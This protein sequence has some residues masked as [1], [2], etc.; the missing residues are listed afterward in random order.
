MSNPNS[1]QTERPWV[2]R[3]ST[4]GHFFTATRMVHGRAFRVV[5]LATCLALMASKSPQANG[6]GI[7]ELEVKA[8]IR[9]LGDPSFAARVRA[10]EGL[11]RMGLQAFD[12]LHE[13]QFNPDSEIAMTARFLVSSL[14]VQWHTD[15][16][17][18]VVRE[19]L[20]EYGAQSESE[21]QNR[22]DR[23][24]ELPARQGLAA[25]CRLARYET[26][27]RLSRHAALAIMRGTISDD[28]EVR[29]SEAETILSVLGSNDRQASN[30]LR[31]Y[32]NDL[33]KGDYD[34]EAWNR[35]VREQ[36]AAADG[37]DPNL[38]QPVL[39]ELVRV[40]ANRALS[41]DRPEEALRLA[42]E[43]L[44]LVPPEY[45]DLIDACGWAIDSGLHPLVLRL[46][47]LHPQ[48]FEGRPLLLY[49]AAEAVLDVEKDAE[50]AEELAEK[51]AAIDPLKP[52]AEGDAPITRESEELGYRHRLIARQLQARGLFR[53]AEREYRHIID[54]LPLTSRASAGARVDFAKMLGELLRHREVVEILLP[55]I[56]RADVDQQFARDAQRQA[57]DLNMMRSLVYFHR[58][59]DEVQSKTPEKL[60]AA[61]QSFINALELEPRNIDILI[62]MYR[63]DGDE[64]WKR[65]IRRQIQAFAVMFDNLIEM[66]ESQAQARARFMNSKE[67]LAD[68][69]NQYAWLISNT[70]GDLRKALQYSLKSLEIT[71]NQSA[72]LDTCGRCYFAL[73]DLQ[74]AILVQ[75]RAIK[76][77]PHSPAM[78]RQLAEFEAAATAATRKV[79]QP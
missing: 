36:R 4:T 48:Q 22:M 60:L 21:R 15:S 45:D 5:S 32:V 28:S 31:T 49:G 71:P 39:L 17:P 61:R 7:D 34:A 8:L 14:L 64:T 73:G 38:S 59:L 51:A 11:E 54:S 9:Q 24:A 37:K 26:S 79:D 47:A 6:D 74:N 20:N 57:V 27:L 29:S 25:L 18:P 12:Y 66:S 46:R 43:H 35:L 10:R 40:C 3:C 75:R 63:L 2:N 55:M 78:G 77:E 56:E 19:T 23:L 72:L 62:A 30:W 67:E 70:E 44:D 52:H 50:A 58:G 68:L 76:I 16:D 41:A 42:D 33:R 1:P 65:D 13:E 69:Y 53:W